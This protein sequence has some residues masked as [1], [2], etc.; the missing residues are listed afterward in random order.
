[1]L[2]ALFILYTYASVNNNLVLQ[3]NIFLKSRLLFLSYSITRVYLDFYCVWWQRAIPLLKFVWCFC[4]L[5]P[6]KL[7]FTNY[8]RLWNYNIFRNSFSVPVYYDRAP[9]LLKITKF[10]KSPCLFWLQ[11]IRQIRAQKYNH[12]C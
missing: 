4:A 7:Q 9:C 3:F 11:L 2:H 1:M 12:S 8:V 6:S 5:M 10:S